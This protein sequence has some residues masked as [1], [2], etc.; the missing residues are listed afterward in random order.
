[1]GTQPPSIGN[2][3]QVF[4]RRFRQSSSQKFAP[5]GRMLLSPYETLVYKD[6]DILEFA[7]IFRLHETNNCV[8]KSVDNSLFKSNDP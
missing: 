2:G 1:M 4:S 6:S 3:G 7:I 5:E 8:L